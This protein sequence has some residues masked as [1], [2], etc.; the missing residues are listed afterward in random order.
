MILLASSKSLLFEII[1]AHE[2]KKLESLSKDIILSKLNS[3]TNLK[4]NLIS[5]KGILFNT[6]NANPQEGVV[7]VPNLSIT[8][9]THTAGKDNSFVLKFIDKSKTFI[10]FLTVAYGIEALR[11]YT[12]ALK[13]IG[14]L[15]ITEDSVA[16]QKKVLFSESL[17]PTFQPLLYLY[18]GLEDTISKHSGPHAVAIKNIY[19]NLIGADVETTLV[20]VPHIRFFGS[21]NGQSLSTVIGNNTAG[22]HEVK[23]TSQLIE[24]IKG[25]AYGKNTVDKANGVNAYPSQNTT[26]T[27]PSQISYYPLDIHLIITDIIKSYITS[28]TGS[29]NIIVLLPDLNLYLANNI[30]KF[31]ESTTVGSYYDESKYAGIFSLNDFLQNNLVKDLYAPYLASFIKNQSIINTLKD[32]LN[33]NLIYDPFP[34]SQPP[35]L[36]KD[37]FKIWNDILPEAPESKIRLQISN[38]D[39]ANQNPLEF[40]ITGLFNKLK[41]YSNNAFDIQ[42][43]SESNV[44]LNTLWVDQKFKN[45]YTLPGTNSNNT[46]IVCGDPILI[47]KY[48]Y[49]NKDNSEVISIPLHPIDNKFIGNRSY[50]EE[51]NRLLNYDIN[52][53]PNFTTNSRKTSNDIKVRRA[54]ISQ[55]AAYFA[56]FQNTISQTLDT[57]Q[58]AGR[59]ILSEVLTNLV[60]PKFDPD[61]LRTSLAEIRGKYDKNVVDLLLKETKSGLDNITINNSNTIASDLTTRKIELQ[62]TLDEIISQAN[63]PSSGGTVQLPP[64]LLLSPGEASAKFNRELKKQAFEISVETEPCYEFGSYF[65]VGKEASLDIHYL[66][67]SLPSRYLITGYKHDYDPNV[68]YKSQFT[69]RAI[70]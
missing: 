46:T 10:N 16:N 70:V 55:D 35:G 29:D 7:Q 28:L 40:L 22:K 6:I 61:S 47:E 31:L 58:T 19:I 33:L 24:L 2:D 1:K 4:N 5:G 52:R 21:I 53:N 25:V 8:S 59:S 23:G 63:Q 60:I 20:L 18:Y 54:T 26:G 15:E 13:N 50:Y 30:T 68:G 37:Q 45:S 49:G 38:Q 14:E 12:E 42:L 11:G 17:D 67:K 36:T 56:A 62:T 69:L 51:V 34:L 44:K 3:N 48:L 66:P 64:T 39:S 43:F 41:T 65:L 27:S 57:A 9:L 32:E